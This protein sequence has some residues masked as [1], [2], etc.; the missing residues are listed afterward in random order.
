MKKRL[1]KEEIYI[2]ET[3]DRFTLFGL[4]MKFGREPVD[5]EIEHLMLAGII[6]PLYVIYNGADIGECVIYKELSE[7]PFGTNVFPTNQLLT[8]NMVHIEYSFKN[9]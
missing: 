1:L 2:Y 4:Y 8:E 6:R 7:I 5:N 3:H 9:M